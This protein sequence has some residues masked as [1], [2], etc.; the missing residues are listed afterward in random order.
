M[1]I[2]GLSL[3]ADPEKKD[4][5][6]KTEVAKECVFLLSRPK[7]KRFLYY[8]LSKNLGAILLAES[9]SG[10]SEGVACYRID[11]AIRNMHY[12]IIFAL[13]PSKK[14]LKKTHT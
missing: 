5:G 6:T 10:V 3:A 8:L 9:I 11:K 7:K 2:R 13:C 1:T 14:I 4:R 12:K